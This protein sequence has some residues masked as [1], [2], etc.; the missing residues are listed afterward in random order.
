MSERGA[1]SIYCGTTAGVVRVD[2]TTGA[3]SR[4]AACIAWNRW[5]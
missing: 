2:G 1:V 3:V 4:L 5:R